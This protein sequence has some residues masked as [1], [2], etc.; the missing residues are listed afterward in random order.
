MTS[1][2]CKRNVQRRQS[3]ACQSVEQTYYKLIGNTQW[4]KNIE[5]KKEEQLLESKQD[6]IHEILKMENLVETE[7]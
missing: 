3:S 2:A 7:R 5:L 6:R 4:I 1:I